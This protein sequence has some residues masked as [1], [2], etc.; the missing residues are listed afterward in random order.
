MRVYVAGPYTGDEEAN[1][2]RAIAQGE[3]LDSLGFNSFVPHLFHFWD[4]QHPAGYERWMAKCLAEV[5]RSD[6]LF[7]TEG[8]SPGASREEQ[9]ADERGI[10]VVWSEEELT[11]WKARLA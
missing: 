3:R 2:S 6:V 5:E 4:R 10:R 7:R 11:A 1:V 9:R 8:G